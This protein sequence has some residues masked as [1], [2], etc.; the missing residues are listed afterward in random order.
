MCGNRRTN[1]SQ[2][3]LQKLVRSK[4]NPVRP[5]CTTLAVKTN[6]R[7][8]GRDPVRTGAPWGVLASIRPARTSSTAAGTKDEQQLGFGKR[9]GAKGIK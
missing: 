6:E 7:P 5:V 9:I 2:Q 1:N 4:V 3:N 8:F